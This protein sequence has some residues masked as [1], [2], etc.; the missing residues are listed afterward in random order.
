M[1]PNAIPRWHNAI[2]AE[3][4]WATLELCCHT[5]PSPNQMELLEDA[6]TLSLNL[7]G[8]RQAKSGSYQ[9]VSRSEFFPMGDVMFQPA[10]TR[11]L[12]CGAGG[13]DRFLR[14]SFNAKAVG[15]LVDLSPDHARLDVQSDLLKVRS[16]SLL[17]P[18]RRALIEIEAPGMASGFLLE[19]LTM[20]MAV[21]LARYFSRSSERDLCA[22]S[23]LAPWQLRRIDERIHDETTTPP[24]IAELSALVRLSPRHLSRAYRISRGATLSETVELARQAR[25]ESMVRS[26]KLQLKEIAYRLGFTHASGFSTAFRRRAGCSPQEFSRRITQRVP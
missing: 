1:T 18:L 21:E 19:G 24:T 12:T 23:G 15:E 26:G 11:L 22:R 25:A 10:G 7:S 9:G 2:P 16:P 17:P 3:T 13:H 4:R 14:I 6:P 20:V 5:W 8:S